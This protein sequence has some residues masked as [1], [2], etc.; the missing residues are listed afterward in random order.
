MDERDDLQLERPAPTRVGPV[1][2][3]RAQRRAKARARRRRSRAVVLLAC[4]FMLVVVGGLGF[5]IKKWLNR[6]EL[7]PDYNGPGGKEVVIQ[8]KTGDTAD[9]IAQQ[10]AKKDVTASAAAFY[11]AAV[12]NDQMDKLQ[13][14][15][16]A[17]PTEISGKRAVDKLV[18]PSSR[19]G[20]VLLTEGRQ[21][22]DSTDVNTHARKDGIYTK[23]AEASCYGTG[24]DKKCITYDELN[25][26]GASPDLKSLG[27][28][29]WALDAVSK[30]PDHDRQLEGLIPSGTWD[31]DPTATPTQI[32]RQLVSEGASTYEKAGI[33]EQ[34][35]DV[36]LNP[37]Q[38]L[39]AASLVERESLPPDFAKVARVILNRLAVNRPLEFDSTV[40]YALERTEVATTD[41]DRAKV[42]PWNTYAMP[43]L[44]ATPIASPS[45]PALEAIEKPAPG[46]WLYFVTVDKQGTTLFTA[47]Y[48]EHLRNIDRAKQ[49]GILDSGR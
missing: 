35:P 17:I 38:K 19:V 40:N 15:Y 4:A 7:A 23:I 8:V 2:G 24:G 1:P 45:V 33:L 31:F 5:G 28:P 26:A 27:V 14:G 36:P 49:S 37:Y 11:E 16:Y 6:S 13:P 34:T 43:G 41:A 47:D 10:M 21:L 32:L 3:S 29:D 42:T 18:D 20:H 46:N 44:P 48:D 30:V 25:T 22:H 39:I 12:A 9:Q